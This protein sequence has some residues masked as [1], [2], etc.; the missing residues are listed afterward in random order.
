MSADTLK[1]T[2]HWVVAHPQ[3]AVY[4]SLCIQIDQLNT[5][6]SLDFSLEVL[7]LF[8]LGH[9]NELVISSLLFVDCGFT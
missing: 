3:S 2:S 9:R 4:T 8:R 1:R 7:V 6:F 5:K